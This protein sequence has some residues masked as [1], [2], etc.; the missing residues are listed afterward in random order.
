M[1]T[2]IIERHNT[3]LEGFPA[4]GFASGP[5]FTIHWQDGPNELH[6]PDCDAEGCAPDCALARFPGAFVA[7][8]IAAAISRLEH[9][10]TTPSAH[11]A[12]NNARTHLFLALEELFDSR[13]PA[14]QEAP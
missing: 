12:Y 11:P 7:H 2:H 1:D 13:N 10:Q 3:S 5:G 14:H 9:Y 4:G 6:S 8:I